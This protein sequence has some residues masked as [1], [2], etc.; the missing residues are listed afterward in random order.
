MLSLTMKIKIMFLLLILAFLNIDPSHATSSHEIKEDHGKEEKSSGGMDMNLKRPVLGIEVSRAIMFEDIIEKIK[1]K[2]IIYVGEQHDRYEHHLVQLEIIKALKERGQDIAI[3][4]EMFLHKY[5]MVLNDYI[6]GRIDEREFLKSSHYFKTWGFDY[7]LYRDILNF[8]R[9]NRIPVI[10]L[11]LPREIVN[12]V[13]RSGIDS[14]T[15]E[16]KKELPSDMEMNDE[17]YKRRLKETFEKHEGS[18]ERDFERF[19]QSQIIWDE[20]MAQRIDEYMKQ[21]PSKK[22]VVIVGGGHLA[23]SSGIP[24]RAFRRNGLSHAVILNNEDVFTGIADYILYPEPV[25][26]PETPKL[27]T[28]LKDDEEGVRI[29]GFPEKSISKKAGL[30]EGDLIVSI[31]GEKVNTVDDIKILL[32]YK[33]KGD[34]IKVGVRRKVFLFGERL[35]QFDITL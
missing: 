19:Y 32:I 8:A 6:E 30:M 5:Q 16:E 4:M 21:N 35:R 31:D 10:G 22:M 3:G 25:S 20:I 27:M 14:L 23:Y 2:K 29:T 24:K 28:M 13:G 17:E 1:D 7:L 11:N 26:E 34:K 12:K 18:E 33:K 15:E 9:E